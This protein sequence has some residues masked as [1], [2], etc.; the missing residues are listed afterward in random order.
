MSYLVPNTR[1]RAGYFNAD[2]T[3]L[4]DALKRGM[5]GK[6]ASSEIYRR[7]FN[8]VRHV[9]AWSAWRKA[10]DQRFHEPL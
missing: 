5:N 2:N 7:N 1:A 6:R 4:F 8:E 10:D 3:K 9:R